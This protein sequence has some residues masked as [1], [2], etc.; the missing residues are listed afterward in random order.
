MKSYNVTD[1]YIKDGNEF[2]FSYYSNPPMSKKLSFVK[3]VVDS[4]VVGDYY[5]SIIKDMV[6]DFYL[7]DFFSDI[8]ININTD[9]VGV[10]DIEEYLSGNNAAAT[11]KLGMDLMVLNELYD[12][13]EKGIEYKTG[14]HP[15]PIEDA[16][17]NVLDVVQNKLSSLDVDAMTGM[18]NVFSNMSGNITPEK[19]LEAY[20]KSDVFKKQHEDVVT[21]QAKRDKTM[22]SVREIVKRDTA[23]LAD[24]IVDDKVVQGSFEVL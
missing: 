7:I 1:V 13:V 24:S 8:L 17:V 4:V 23:I 19:M 15:S 16:I 9:N 21:K 2:E 10:D 20:A 11:I 14:I 18:A 6:F 12:S 22:D 5:Y 3:S